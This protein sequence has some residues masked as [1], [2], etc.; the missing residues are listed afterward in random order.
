MKI[1]I[2]TTGFVF[3]FLFLLFSCK[4]QAEQSEQADFPLDASGLVVTD[5]PIAG[6]FYSKPEIINIDLKK[7]EKQP[8]ENFYDS[9]SFVRLETRV[10][11]LIGKISQIVFA[12]NLIIVVDK[13]NSKS[14]CVFDRNG[15]FRNKIGRIGN[16]PGEYI[17]IENVSLVPGKKQLAVFDGQTSRVHYF[18]YT[19]EYIGSERN[20]FGAGHMEFLPSGNKAFNINSFGLGNAVLKEY[21]NGTLLVTDTAGRVMYGA[22]RSFYNENK[23]VSVMLNSLW[24]FGGEVYHSPNFSNTIYHVGDSCLT[25][26]YQL[27]IKGSLPPISDNTVDEIKEKVKNKKPFFNGEL[28]ILKDLVCINIFVLAPV[29]NPLVI[30]S[31]AAKKAYYTTGGGNHPFHDFIWNISPQARY[32]DNTLV[33]DIPSFVI[34]NRREAFNAVKDANHRKILDELYDGLTEDDNPVLFFCKMNT[35]LK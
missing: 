27:N 18:I 30:Y 9:I 28:I 24:S 25:V 16:G 5:N 15:R 32:G 33:F 34:N 29:G 35:N 1:L 11:N 17:S 7:G 14:I 4:R 19:G 31:K 26:A 8:L 6:I 22:G 10:D 2:S 21:R 13:W 20:Q 3:I 12:D 23:F